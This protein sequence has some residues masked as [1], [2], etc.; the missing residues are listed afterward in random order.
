MHKIMD[1]NSY[2]SIA[3][4]NWGIISSFANQFQIGQVAPDTG[5]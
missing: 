5:S 3:Q 2:K 1:N 4:V